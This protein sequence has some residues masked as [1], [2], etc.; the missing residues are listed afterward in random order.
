MSKCIR[1]NCSLEEHFLILVC[2]WK[3]DTCVNLHPCYTPGRT[4]ILRRVRVRVRARALRYLLRVVV[5]R[6][7]WL[8]RPEAVLTFTFV[9][10]VGLE[11][12]TRTRRSLRRH[13]SLLCRLNVNTRAAPTPADLQSRRTVKHRDPA[14][15]TSGRTERQQHPVMT[16]KIKLKC[17]SCF[18]FPDV[19]LKICL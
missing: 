7:M 8:P 3:V 16:Y 9:K 11:L 10:N 19:G 2:W 1:Y 5:A 18:F 6:Q 17:F 15:L 14:A 4:S 13:V 12:R